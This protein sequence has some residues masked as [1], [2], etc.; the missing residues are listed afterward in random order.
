MDGVVFL[1]GHAIGAGASTMIEGVSCG[2]SSGRRFRGPGRDRGEEGVGGMV[3]D[4]KGGKR[5]KWM[6]KE[7]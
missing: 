1:T 2:D 4:R 3:H 5:S 7:L 6:K